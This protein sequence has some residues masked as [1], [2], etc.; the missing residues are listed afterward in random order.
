MRVLKPRGEE[1]T[2]SVCFGDPQKIHSQAFPALC[3]CRISGPGIGSSPHGKADATCNC[4]TWFWSS[5]I[6]KVR[7]ILSPSGRSKLLQVLFGNL[8]GLEC[9][10]RQ[11]RQ[12]LSLVNL[13]LFALSCFMV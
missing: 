13:V 2:A 1:R 9:L 7:C 3:C 10:L 12:L 8:G 6:H 5:Q 11:L 4:T